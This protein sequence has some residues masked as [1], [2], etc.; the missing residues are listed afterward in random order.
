M[1]LTPQR[2]S[3]TQVLFASIYKSEHGPEAAPATYSQVDSADVTQ[4]LLSKRGAALSPQ[5]QRDRTG[6]HQL[7]EAQEALSDNRMELRHPGL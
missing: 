5:P 3:G 2:N 6:C 4:Q 1:E 7:R